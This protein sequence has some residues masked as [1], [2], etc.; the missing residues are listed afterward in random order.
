MRLL[1]LV[2]DAW[3]G[4]GGIAKVNRDFL[5][6][7]AE[8]PAVDEVVVLPRVIVEAPGPTP[9]GVDYRTEAAGGAA[10]FLR[11]FGA[12]LARGG[13]DGVVGGHLNLTPLAAVAAMRAR[14]PWFFIVHGV[15]GWG[16]EHWPQSYGAGREAAVRWAV[17][18]ADAFVSVSDLT[19]QRFS[20]WMGVP[21]ERGVV[22]PNSVDV[23]AFGVGPKRTDLLERYGL[24]GKTVVM[25]LA[26]LS[27][28]EQYKGIDE[29]LEALPALVPEFPDLA[30]LVCGS[31]DDRE[32]LEAK[33][34]AL[35]LGDRVVFAGYV[36]EDEKADHYRLADAFSMPGRGEGFGIVYLEA[37]ACGVPV[38]ASSADASR[39]A[40]LNG[41]IGTIV[42]PDDPA[43][44][45]DG[46]R[47]ALRQP[48]GVPDRLDHFSAARFADRWRSV[49]DRV[50]LPA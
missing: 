9:P 7:F 10:A 26:R 18:R 8:H 44:V 45:V 42:D 12:V 25:T 38:V 3:G 4:R 34:R 2:T 41:E 29:T 14:A 33:A 5:A 22:I 17:Q 6:A 20:Q 49:V 40:V 32:R 13:Y 50:F 37:L 1:A 27:A 30:Y 11:A 48:A 36:A 16:P 31:G 24:G 47:T 43:S 35:G 19:R 21:A 23:S 39:E 46:L 15:D 28:A